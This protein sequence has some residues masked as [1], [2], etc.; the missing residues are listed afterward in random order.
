MECPPLGGAPGRTAQAQIT[1]V[2]PRGSATPSDR[3]AESV[4]PTYI[5]TNTN[6]I[7]IAFNGGTPTVFAMTDTS[8]GCSGTGSATKCTFAVPAPV[9]TSVSTAL[10]IYQSTN[11]TGT[12]L[13]LDTQ[14][15]AIAA[16]IVNNISFTLNPVVASYSL[17]WEGGSP[18]SFSVDD[19]SAQTGTLL[20]TV[21]DPSGATVIA[22]GSYVTSNGSAVTFSVSDSLPNSAPYTTYAVSGLAFT[23]SGTQPDA[24]SPPSNTIAF[25]YKGLS[26]PQ[27]TFTVTDSANIQAAGSSV[28]L[29]AHYGAMT[30]TV[31]CNEAVDVCSNATGNTAGGTAGSISFVQGGDTATIA[32]AETG[33]TDAP[34]SQSGGGTGGSCTGGS[35]GSTLSGTFWTWTVT[36]NTGD[37]PGTCRVDIFDNLSPDQSETINVSYT[38]EQIVIDRGHRTR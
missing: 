8:P 12:P 36:A 16:G 27:T 37:N 21:L 31:T 24:G 17:A 32:V 4:R 34:Y 35:A 38:Y 29:P 7:S 22:P 20:L 10:A 5:S 30:A 15:V 3:S 14:N 26:I 18:P 23:G 28:T 33:W 6:S 25:T 19:S 11:G 9:G 1:V 2:I 13:A